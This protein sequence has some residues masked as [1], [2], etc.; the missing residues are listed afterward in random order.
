MGQKVSFAGQS[1]IGSLPPVPRVRRGECSVC[2][3]G[4]SGCDQAR[5]DLTRAH[6]SSHERTSESLTAGPLPHAHWEPGSR[7]AQCT[8]FTHHHY[9]I[10]GIL[11]RVLYQETKSY[12]S[13][14]SSSSCNTVIISLTTRYQ[15]HCAFTT[16]ANS[17][18][19]DRRFLCSVSIS[20]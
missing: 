11:V 12:L 1:T 18:S 19:D 10:T 14:S 15:L 7:K 16:R 3:F 8:N 6:T 9:I 20:V 13:S 2:R 17:Q 5:S 4:R